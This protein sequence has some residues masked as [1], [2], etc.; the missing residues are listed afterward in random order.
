M[1]ISGLQKA[2]N[3]AMYTLN[4]KHAPFAAYI[5]FTSHEVSLFFNQSTMCK[6]NSDFFPFFKPKAIGLDSTTQKEVLAI[7]WSYL[8]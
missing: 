8:R 5:C 1:H 6:C 7:Y 4:T 2:G 3:S